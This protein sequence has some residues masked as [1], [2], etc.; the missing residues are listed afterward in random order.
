MSVK[1]TVEGTKQAKN[2]LIKK[3]LKTHFMVNQAMVKAGAFMDGEVKSSIAGHRAEPVSVDTGNFLR[4]VTFKAFKDNAVIYSDVP[5]AEFLEYGTSRIK[6][7][8]K[9][10]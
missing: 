7:R 3:N 6:A 10:L 1:I 2:F 8:R 4:S 5:Y 9:T